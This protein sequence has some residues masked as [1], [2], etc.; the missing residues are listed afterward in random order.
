MN[1]TLKALTSLLLAGTAAL[2]TAAVAQAGPLTCTDLGSSTQC[3]SEG[4]SQITANPPFIRDRTEIIII[5]RH[6]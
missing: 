4:N 2:G 6:R 3:G 1:I 5:H